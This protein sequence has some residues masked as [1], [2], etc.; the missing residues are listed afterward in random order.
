MPRASHQQTVYRQWLILRKLTTRSPGI[1]AR[2]MR[3]YL[4]TEDVS[5]TKRTV[6]RDLNELSCIFPLET[7][8]GSPPI[9]WRWRK[10]AVQELPGLELADALSLSLVGDLLNQ[11]LPASL[12]PSISARVEEARRKL[13]ALPN[14][15]ASAWSQLVRYVPPGQ[16]LLKPQV[17]P[18]ILHAVEEGLVG[19][20]QLSICYQAP[21]SPEPWS[22]HMHPI[23]LLSHGS[24]PYLLGC[25][26]KGTEIWQYPLHRFLSVELTE[27]PS[28]RPRDF[29]L[30]E[31]LAQGQATFGKGKTIRLE[32]L[33]DESLAKILSETPLSDNQTIREKDDHYLLKASVQQSWQLT[34]YLLSQ[35]P[36]I[37]VLKP[38]SLRNEIM[39]NLQAALE[40][41]NPS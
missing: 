28:W 15:T 19:Q 17:D 21:S 13:D 5:V 25:L 16:P 36:R 12:H 3:D 41:Y 34:F 23:A 29:D 32:A 22:T 35:G 7:S 39:A 31:F 11:T 40:N 38:K 1:T 20:K 14:H 6:E 24:T 33:L 10:D 18:N 37:T 30:D 2:E 9:G 8:V 26:G 4:E 27:K